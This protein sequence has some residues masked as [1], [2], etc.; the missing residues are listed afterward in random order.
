M[1]GCA[2]QQSRVFPP[3]HWDWL[4]A[5]LDQQ[6]SGVTSIEAGYCEI[7]ITENTLHVKA[8]FED[9]DLVALGKVDGEEHYRL[10]DCGEVFLQPSGA[11]HYWEIWVAPTGYSTI[12]FRNSRGGE[13]EAVERI[14][15]RRIKVWTDVNGTL[16]DGVA[17][18]SGWAMNLE[19][20]LPENEEA[21]SWR[22]LVARQN[23]DSRMDKAV[24]ELSSFPR[25]SETDFHR[26][27]EYREF[28]VTP[29]EDPRGISSI[30]NLRRSR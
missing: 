22:V 15:G 17:D 2:E 21:R 27:D 7:R 1:A 20:P 5:P 12:I 14:D 3:K 18:D 19:I 26:T 23:Y 25:L 30:F 13:R 28:Y 16:N 6:Q 4:Q 8:Y 24:R 10:G 11:E 29:E 9:S